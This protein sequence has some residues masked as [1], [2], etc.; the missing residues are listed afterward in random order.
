MIQSPHIEKQI[1]TVT[2]TSRFNLKLNIIRGWS[3]GDSIGH[4]LHLDLNQPYQDEVQ[5]DLFADGFVTVDIGNVFD[6]WFASHMAVRRRR[7]R[8]HPQFT[9]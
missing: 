2:I 1:N 8:Q 5:E 7:H 6:L 3:Y 9:T 4:S